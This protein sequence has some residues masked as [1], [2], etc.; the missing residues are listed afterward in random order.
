MCKV[1]IKNSNMQVFL[2]MHAR[3]LRHDKKNER[4]GIFRFLCMGVQVQVQVQACHL[5][6]NT[7]TCT[8]RQC[9]PTFVS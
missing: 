8:C 1:K 6:K 3:I 7:C 2:H 9:A 5:R 4:F